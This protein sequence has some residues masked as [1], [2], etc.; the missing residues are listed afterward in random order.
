MEQPGI[1]QGWT[2]DNQGFHYLLQPRPDVFYRLQD[3]KVRLGNLGG[4]GPASRHLWPYKQQLEQER[5]VLMHE[6]RAVGDYII[7]T[8]PSP[9]MWPGFAMHSW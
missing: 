9:V 8:A 2:Q 7:H 6:A 5:R 4:I 1:E 3:L